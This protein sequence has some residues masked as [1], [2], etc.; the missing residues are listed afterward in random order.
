[1]SIYGNYSA[2]T[3]I[4]T[5]NTGDKIA[6]SAFSA[7][8]G[9]GL[10]DDTDLKAYWK[11]DEADTPIPNSSVSDESLGSAAEWAVTNGTYQQESPPLNTAI[12]WNG[13]NASAEAG[14]SLSDWNFLHN[15]TALFTLA[16][17]MKMRA[18]SGEGHILQ[19][20][21]LTTEIGFTITSNGNGSISYR[22]YTGAGQNN[23]CDSSTAYLP[24]TTTWYFYTISFS[25][26]LASSNCIFSR[27]DS[28][29]STVN[30]TGGTNSNN[31]ATNPLIVGSKFNLAEG[32][33]NGWTNEVSL[34]E[35]ILSSDDEASLYNDGAG[36]EIY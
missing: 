20:T 35:K 33:L 23:A 18:I 32:F 13:T 36:L 15:T 3:K 26:V 5:L 31:N 29:I 14:T 30:K 6:S 16:W 1:M 2:G 10:G 25:E 21:N 22:T 12:L 11:C 8:N 7:G 24:N 34:W 28:V 19:T 4:G 17:W 27:D 9:G